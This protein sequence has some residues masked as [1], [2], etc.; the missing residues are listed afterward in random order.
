MLIHPGS[1]LQK[2]AGKWIVAAEISETTRLFARCVARIEPEWLEVVGAHLLK[3]SHFDPHWEK[4]AMQAVAFERITLY[5]IVG[6]PRRRVNFGP[7]NPPQHANC[8][9]RDAL[10]AGGGQ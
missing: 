1:A 3:R 4:K 8:S 10:V 7:L 5:G 9:S 2:K 6:D